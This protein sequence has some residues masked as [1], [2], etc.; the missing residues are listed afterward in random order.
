MGSRR[1]SLLGN[2]RAG[3]GGGDDGAE[4]PHDITGEEPSEAAPSDAGGPTDPPPAAS[5]EP[6]L[7]PAPALPP[8]PAPPPSSSALP[9]PPP[10]EVDSFPAPKPSLRKVG[11]SPVPT[12][13][14]WEVEPEPP[15]RKPAPREAPPPTVTRSGPAEDAAV[16][17]DL[18]KDAGF[19]AL[20]HLSPP[21]ED[22][23][24]AVVEDVAQTYSSPYSVPEPP[25][26]PELMNRFTPSPVVRTEL[27]ERRRKPDYLPDT[28]A[29]AEQRSY[30]PTPPPS[31]PR[32]KAGG[33]SQDG[34]LPIP[35]L[36]GLGA[37]AVLGVG[38][39][40]GLVWFFGTGGGDR[41]PVGLA[42]EAPRTTVE[43]RDD[44]R[45]KPPGVGEEAP[46][47]PDPAPAPTP[48][49]APVAEA[50]PAPSP[51]DPAPRPDPKPAAPKPSAPPTAPASQPAAPAP[52]PVADTQGMLKVRANRRAMVYVNNQVIGF[53]PLDHKVAPG[54]WSVAA[55]LPG[56]PTTRQERNV[57]VQAAGATTAID[58]TF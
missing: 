48:E 38:L 7:P 27:G 40:L 58:F 1:R 12:P 11:V 20:D 3:S 47:A 39:V 23:P 57:S 37:V 4:L 10:W 24:A 35:M 17:R 29:G 2:K 13:P 54:T 46:P 53:T 31:A 33:K 22:R 42:P 45:R 16:A 14:P 43:T 44:M 30:E 49:A 25:P 15:P 18:F 21:T 55:V 52:A 26:I 28:P 9:S 32:R 34:G 6:A 41:E 8:T 56:Q 5:A 51:A 36:A 50:P 19:E